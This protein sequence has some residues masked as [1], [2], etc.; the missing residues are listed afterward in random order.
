[1]NQERKDDERV[2]REHLFGIPT[3]RATP[4]V[5][6]PDGAHH[7]ARPEHH[8]AQLGEQH[9]DAVEH[10]AHASGTVI[11]S[12]ADRTAATRRAGC[13]A[14]R[15][16]HFHRLPCSTDA[17]ECQAAAAHPPHQVAERRNG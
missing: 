10:F 4:T 1:M 15:S 9:G 2:E 8:K 17:R 14:A 6:G 3:P 5:V 7:D 13:P 16:H 11:R 12:L